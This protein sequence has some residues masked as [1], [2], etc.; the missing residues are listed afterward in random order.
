MAEEPDGHRSVQ[1]WFSFCAL[2]ENNLSPQVALVRLKLIM[3]CSS[4]RINQDFYGSTSVRLCLFV[5][6]F[7]FFFGA[8][9][10]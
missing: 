1:V 10:E 9:R 5:F 8:F 2:T 4:L 7:G 6:L 3:M